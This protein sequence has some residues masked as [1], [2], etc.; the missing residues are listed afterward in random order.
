MGTMLHNIGLHIFS[1]TFDKLPS[2]AAATGVENRQLMAELENPALSS[3]FCLEDVG[4]SLDLLG[5]SVGLLVL[6]LIRYGCTTLALALDCTA[7]TRQPIGAVELCAGLFMLTLTYKISL[8]QLHW[9]S[10]LLSLQRQGSCLSEKRCRAKGLGPL[11]WWAPGKRSDLSWASEQYILWALTEGFGGQGRPMNGC[12]GQGRPTKAGLALPIRHFAN[13]ELYPHVA[14]KK[15]RW[16][17]IW[18]LVSF[19]RRSLA[20]YT[21]YAGV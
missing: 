17:K 16:R 5:P 18:R 10:C 21:V 14:N 2:T 6:D 19:W 8:E 4:W 12:G 7:V 20:I 1:T 9:Q 15:S 11:L 3:K 13:D